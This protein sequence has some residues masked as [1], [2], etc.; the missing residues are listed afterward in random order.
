[1]I[2][3]GQIKLGNGKPV[4][5]K[6]LLRWIVAGKVTSP[7]NNMS[8]CCNFS[9]EQELDETLRKFWKIEN[10][11]GAQNVI[12]EDTYCEKHFKETHARNSQGRFIVKLPVKKNIIKDIGNSK[13]I[14]LKRF[15]SL[16]KRLAREPDLK[17]EYVK[18]LKEYENLG[19][20]KLID[21]SRNKVSRIFLPHQAVIKEYSE[22]T[23]V[24][25]VFDASSKDSKGISLNDALYKGPT[26]QSD[27]FSIIL[28]FRW[29]KYVLTADI[30]KMY[31]Q[32]LI[33]EEQTCLQTILWRENSS[34]MS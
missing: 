27:L 17:A 26:I 33:H 10:I 18:F 6:T 7:R 20:M 21:D 5:Q 13:D 32:T 23:K 16:E 31:R 34:P 9:C 30:A 4:L 15:L 14:A 29:F 8:V 3:V 28:K 11:H 25:V 24:R 19:H 2:C 1:M 22:T 12:S